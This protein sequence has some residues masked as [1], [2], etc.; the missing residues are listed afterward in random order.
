MQNHVIIGLNAVIFAHQNNTLCVLVTHRKKHP[1]LPFGPLNLSQPKTLEM[2]LRKR[3]TEQTGFTL[4]YVEQVYTFGD[5]GRD[6]DLIIPLQTIQNPG[7]NNITRVISI[8]YMGLARQAKNVEKTG[9]FWEKVD[10]FFPYETLTHP[11]TEPIIP[12][13]LPDLIRWAEQAKTAKETHYRKNRIARAFSQKNHPWNEEKVLERYELLYEAKLLAEVFADNGKPCPR[14]HHAF[15]KSMISDHR[16][17]L[18]TSL[19][20]LRSKIKY[21]PILFELLPD[22]FTLGEAQNLAEAISGF[23]LHK[24]NFRRALLKTGMLKGLKQFKTPTATGGRPAELYGFKHE[25]L[26]AGPVS[27]IQTPRL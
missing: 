23:A 11:K 22:Q 19:A 21:R 15:G 9:G 4:K 1:A 20:R 12:P 7:Q 17:I 14:T 10:T 2:A 16:R 3:V 5:R 25:I 13:F 24:Q 26:H 27:G 18:A 8:A 6:Q